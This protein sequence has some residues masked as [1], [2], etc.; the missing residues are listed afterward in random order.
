MLLAWQLY[1][2]IHD[3]CHSSI[4]FALV[5]AGPAGVA[6]PHPPPGCHRGR[7][8]PCPCHLWTGLGSKWWRLV[9]QRGSCTSHHPCRDFHYGRHRRMAENSIRDCSPEE[10]SST[11]PGIRLRLRGYDSLQSTER[12]EQKVYHN[13]RN[14]EPAACTAN[15]WGYNEV[16]NGRHPLCTA[17]IMNWQFSDSLAHTRRW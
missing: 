6:Y 12:L 1:Y 10:L 7:R 17:A 16:E 2:Y 9:M 13:Y 15:T 11:P 3:V 14:L 4:Q 8:G 5:S